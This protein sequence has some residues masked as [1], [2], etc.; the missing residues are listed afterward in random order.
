MAAP[1]NTPRDAQDEQPSPFRESQIYKKAKAIA[2]KVASPRKRRNASVSEKF[3]EVRVTKPAG[4]KKSAMNGTL[5]D[6]GKSAPSTTEPNRIMWASEASWLKRVES[7]ED[8]SKKIFD[9]NETLLWATKVT[10]ILNNEIS[11]GEIEVILSRQG[12]LDIGSLKFHVL[13]KGLAEKQSR[14]QCTIMTEFIYNLVGRLII[15]WEE[16]HKDE[17]MTKLNMAE[18]YDLWEAELNK[19][20][21]G[22]IKSM[23]APVKHVVDWHAVYDMD[24]EQLPHEEKVKILRVRL[25]FRLKFVTAC[26]TTYRYRYDD[27]GLMDYLGEGDGLIPRKVSC[28]FILVIGIC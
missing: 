3:T 12:L 21:I 2:D 11:G 5:R 23:W 28:L 4:K 7:A 20:E 9:K 19:D 27:Q 22:V 26:D 17:D 8:V 15:E 18:R 14:W 1:Q 6:T 16:H 25:M 10:Y 24:V 13:A